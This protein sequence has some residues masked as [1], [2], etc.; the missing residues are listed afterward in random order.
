MNPLFL[1]LAACKN[2][3]PT[4]PDSGG[5]TSGTADTSTTG[6][7]ST[8]TA[9]VDSFVEITS[10]DFTGCFETTIGQGAN[11]ET[12]NEADA[13]LDTYVD[14]TPDEEDTGTYF[15]NDNCIVF[16]ATTG[17][18]ETA[19]TTLEDYQKLIL[20]YDTTG[21][22]RTIT[23]GD[24]IFTSGAKALLTII[25]SNV[26]FHGGEED[27]TGNAPLQGG[28]TFDGSASG[29]AIRLEG[30]STL[31]T[32]HVRLRDTKDASP[33]VFDSVATGSLHAFRTIFESIANAEPIQTEGESATV[34]VEHSWYNGAG[35][36]AN[37]PAINATVGAVSSYI[38]NIVSQWNNTS[39]S[40][41]NLSDTSSLISSIQVFANAIFGNASQVLVQGSGELPCAEQ[42]GDGD[43]VRWEEGRF[44][45]N[46]V[47]ENNTTEGAVTS[48][49]ID[50]GDDDNGAC[51][52]VKNNTFVGNTGVDSTHALSELSG[53]LCVKV[54][55]NAYDRN[56]RFLRIVEDSA[57]NNSFR[58]NVIG[59]DNTLSDTTEETILVNGNDNCT[60]TFDGGTGSMINSDGSVAPDFYDILSISACTEGD[61]EG[62]TDVGAFAGSY[63]SLLRE[64]VTENMDL[65]GDYVS[66]T[67]AGTDVVSWS[68]L[69]VASE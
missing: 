63:G 35:A 45:G 28:L 69:P 46:L 13:Y 41:I 11:F 7:T 5:D 4:F 59:T 56:D 62:R 19:P 24:D 57:S 53:D 3:E 32:Q 6:D 34:K 15:K 49:S 68:F 58:D 40:I 22:A 51:L 26:E 42:N 65:F 21:S 25:D 37:A 20:R 39:G 31:L 64:V 2:T 29:S 38:G 54:E 10:G 61:G 17:F 47:A 9:T 48:L 27:R 66:G 14:A 33:I 43:C 23:Y 18:T 50:K 52:Y 36:D 67:Q 44:E 30:T 8:D 16:T 1:L 55:D 60:I 12:I